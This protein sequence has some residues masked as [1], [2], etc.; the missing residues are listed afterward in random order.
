[1]AK[2]LII[3][4]LFCISHI[5]AQ[6]FFYGDS[7][8]YQI[9]DSLHIVGE[10]DSIY[11]SFFKKSSMENPNE[12]P[13]LFHLTEHI[14]TKR[15]FLYAKIGCN[16][17]FWDVY[18]LTERKLGGEAWMYFKGGCYNK[19]CGFSVEHYFFNCDTFSHNI[20]YIF[21]GKEICVSNTTSNGNLIHTTGYHVISTRKLKKMYKGYPTHF[22]NF[23]R[24]TR[25]KYWKK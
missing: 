11:Y 8:I 6:R 22:R 21:W 23:I 20:Q 9:G 14:Y 18:S 3:I 15:G 10:N 25:G 2:F 17:S 1:M 4:A 13:A 12:C 5:Y 24:Y 16:N 19:F 7:L